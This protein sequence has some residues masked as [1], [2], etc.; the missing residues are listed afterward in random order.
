MIKIKNVFYGWWMVVSTAIL[1]L[2]SGAS[3]YYGFTVFFNP[4]KDTFQWTSAET[5]FAFTFQRLES[6]I[7]APIAG[8][9]V[10]RMSARLLMI[11]GWVAAG[12]GFILMSYMDSLWA[13]YSCFALVSIGFSFG[14]MNVPNSVLARWF[15]RKR[16][17]A[18]TCI[19]VG[20]GLSGALVP[21]IALSINHFDW[22]PTLFWVGI[23][24]IT[25]GVLLSM[26]IRDNPRKYGYLPD[27]DK[28]VGN[29]SKNKKVDVPLIQPGFTVKEA[30]KTS[31]FWL[32]G[33]GFLFQMLGTSAVMVHIVPYL[34]NLKIQSTIASLMVTGVTISSLIG[35]IGFGT[36]G[37]FWIK[38]YLI[39]I[40]L[41]LQAIG[42]L[43][44][45]F[46]EADS[47]WLLIPFLLTYAPGYGGPIVLRSA[48]QADYFGTRSLGV[49]M[50]L[51]STIT[52]VG[53]MV[54]P[55][56]VGWMYDIQDTYRNA[57]LVLAA[58]TLPGIVLI[59]MAKPPKVKRAS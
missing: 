53:A 36:L 17:I 15:T 19:Y 57:W 24:L 7:F 47:A 51:M 55:V 27:G 58:A 32:L 42:L 54:S 12:S 44:F 28:P 45:A 2:F 21:L 33:V 41:F 18:F 8:F 31:S 46:V 14:T 20:Y 22:R 30:L 43:I 56:F 34:E 5:S 6:G 23:I 9:L 37:D 39:A 59:L 3:F 48:I 10:D 25:A 4:I 13:F 50:G 26:V 40:A 35:R 16:S 38:R 1:H 29:N 49:L 11:F 52:M